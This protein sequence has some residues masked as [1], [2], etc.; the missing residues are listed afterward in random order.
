MKVVL[1]RVTSASVSVDSKAI[2]SIAKGLVVYVGISQDCTH[3]KLEWMA[4]KMLNLRLWASDQKGF[5][6]SVQDVKGEILVI[7][8]FTLHGVIDGN[9]P[10]FRSAMQ[11]EEAQKMYEVFVELLKNSN[12]KVETGEF[13]AKMDVS[14]VVDGPVNLVLER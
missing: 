5:D 1:Q 2:G 14:S 8:N 4:K 11:Y 12:L 7:S 9:K 13:G 6:L 10:N 3:E